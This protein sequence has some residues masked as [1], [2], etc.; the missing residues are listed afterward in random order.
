MPDKNKSVTLMELLIVMVIFSLIIAGITSINVFSRHHVVS[1]DRRTRVQNEVSFCLEHI[2]KQGL[3]AIGNESIYGVNSAVSIVAN[4]SLSFFVDS[5]SDGRKDSSDTWVSYTFNPS[6][7]RLAFCANCGSS[8]V[9]VCSAANTEVLSDKIVAFNPAKV[10][11]FTQ[12]NHIEVSVT[13]RWDPSQPSAAATS[14]NPE[15]NMRSSIDLPS[16]ST[17]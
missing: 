16:L 11:G 2:T 14:E 6:T 12:G 17:H 10:A 8:P 3:R 1:S 13:A 5:N 15:M 7:Y 9:C 4:S